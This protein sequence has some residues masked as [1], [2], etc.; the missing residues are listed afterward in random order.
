MSKQYLT[1][2]FEEKQL[3]SASWE[4]TSEDGTT[5]WIDS[6]VVIEHIMIAPSEE[7]KKIADVIRQIDFKN[8][9]VN[10]FLKHLAQ[11]LVNNF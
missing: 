10:H 3:P 2:F 11:A 1:T 9:D 8:G 7:Q 4:L 5:H 6:D